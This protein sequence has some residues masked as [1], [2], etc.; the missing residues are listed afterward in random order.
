MT[1]GALSL[2]LISQAC[3]GS[4]MLLAP[5]EPS[6]TFWNRVHFMSTASAPLPLHFCN[7]ITT[8]CTPLTA[9]EGMQA[10]YLLAQDQ[11]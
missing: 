7:C 9:Q 5:V 8:A 3:A 11:G 2:K 1:L 10:V 6:H 4:G